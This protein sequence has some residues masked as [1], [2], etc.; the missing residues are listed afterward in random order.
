ML[1]GIHPENVA[2]EP[3]APP[4]DMFTDGTGGHIRQGISA[5]QKELQMF[6]RKGK[7][8]KWY[9][10]KRKASTDDGP[11]ENKRRC[12]NVWIKNEWC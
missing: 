10:K 8:S 9:K 5:D 7:K 12:C 4:E 11:K 1:V 2:N 6:Q 3:P